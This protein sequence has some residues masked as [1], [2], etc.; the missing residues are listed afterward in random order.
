VLL[1]ELSILMFS[2]FLLKKIILYRYNEIKFHA[3]SKGYKL[4][5]INIVGVVMDEYPSL[6]PLAA[7]QTSVYAYNARRTKDN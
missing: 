1:H 4:I 2:F 3:H 5:N 6:I 7:K